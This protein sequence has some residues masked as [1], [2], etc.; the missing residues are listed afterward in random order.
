MSSELSVIA[1][2]RGKKENKSELVAILRKVERLTQSEAG[3]ISY[4]LYSDVTNPEDFYFLGIW[5]NQVSLDAHNQTNHVLELKA[6]SANLVHSI[7]VTRLTR[8]E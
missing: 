8:F 6:A 2:I 3:C 4:N 1:L 7:E 5:K